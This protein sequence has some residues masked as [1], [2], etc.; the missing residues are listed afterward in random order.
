MILHEKNWNLELKDIW[1]HSYPIKRS[2][3]YIIIVLK[4][5]VLYEKYVVENSITNIFLSICK[6]KF[7]NIMCH[8]IYSC[9]GVQHIGPIDNKSNLII[10]TNIVL[11]LIE[12]KKLK[13]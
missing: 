12:W 6:K 7:T 11:L 9:G 8:N 4:D 2:T 10:L 3:S 1:G 13:Y 5:T